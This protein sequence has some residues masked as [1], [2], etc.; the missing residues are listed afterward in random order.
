MVDQHLIA[1]CGLSYT[2]EFILSVICVEIA[3]YDKPGLIDESSAIRIILRIY[4][5]ILHSG[6]EIEGMR[7]GVGNHDIDLLFADS[8]KEVIEAEDAT[9]SVAIWAHMTSKN[10]L[11]ILIY[12]VLKGTNIFRIETIFH[13]N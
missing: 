11:I 6:E 13:T 3:H 10:N 1:R 8:L 5:D 7:G 2:A 4:G 9:H 12:Q